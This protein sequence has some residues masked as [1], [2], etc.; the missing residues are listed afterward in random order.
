M[1]RITRLE[2]RVVHLARTPARRDLMLAELARVGV[3]PIAWAAVDGRDPANAARLAA[4]PDSGPWG[5]MDTHAKGCLLSHLDAITAFLS[6][7]SSHLLMLEDDVFL[8]DDLPHWLTGDW[9]P[10][11]AEVVKL[12]RW[13][14]DRLL[15]LLDRQTIRHAGR[16]LRRLRSRHSGA[17][18]YLINRAGAQKLRAVVR[19]ALPIDH[20]LF[21]PTVSTLARNLTTYQATPALVVQGNEPA[22]PATA[23]PSRKTLSHK[24]Q[25][26]LAELRALRALSLLLSRRADLSAI[27]WAR[28]AP[29]I[30][31]PDNQ[32]SPDHAPHA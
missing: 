5:P 28:Q 27:T 26:G 25:R 20:L 17:A 12:E 31:A 11:D 13:R 2:T 24:L 18:G 4:L 7:P 8:A 30:G 19:P 10:A 6:G 22:S 29:A 15:V 3:T 14:D 21:N 23:Q 32:E 1:T 9:W 16:D